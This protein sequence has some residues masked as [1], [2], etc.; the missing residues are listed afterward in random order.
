M[1]ITWATLIVLSLLCFLLG[2]VLGVRLTTHKF[3]DWLD[4]EGGTD[5]VKRIYKRM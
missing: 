2:L 1:T 4:V 3:I 5:L